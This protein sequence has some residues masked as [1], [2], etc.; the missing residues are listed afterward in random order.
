[1][2]ST[3]TALANF[4]INSHMEIFFL[5]IYTLWFLVSLAIMIAKMIFFILFVIIFGSSS[6][7]ILTIFLILWYK[8]RSVRNKELR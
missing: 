4:K 2:G 6:L 5:F 8:K 3:P 7:V 1:M